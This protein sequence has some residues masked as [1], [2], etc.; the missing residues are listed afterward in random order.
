MLL[1][2]VHSDMITLGLDLFSGEYLN[3]LLFQW[4]PLIENYSIYEAH[5]VRCFF[6]CK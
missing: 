2:C 3:M 1:Y 4:Y 5:Q 6:V